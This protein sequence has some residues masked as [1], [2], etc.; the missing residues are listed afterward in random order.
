MSSKYSLVK[1]GV[2]VILFFGRD[3]IVCKFSMWARRQ[4]Y[5]LTPPRTT[6]GLFPT[7]IANACAASH[8]SW[9]L[10]CVTLYIPSCSEM[11]IIVPV[12]LFYKLWIPARWYHDLILFKGASHRNS[13]AMLFF[14]LI[15]SCVLSLGMTNAHEQRKY[16]DPNNTWRSGFLF[17]RRPTGWCL[18]WARGGFNTHCECA[19][20]TWWVWVDCWPS[21]KYTRYTVV[22][23]WSLQ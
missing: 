9:S 2:Y 22:S 14:M 3:L 16:L 20:L 6:V 23:S 1:N 5:T 10:Y 7:P 13:T 17:L 8:G 15:P 12:F 4:G 19:G 11:N 21:G 18:S